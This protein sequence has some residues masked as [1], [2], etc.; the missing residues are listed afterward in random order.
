MRWNFVDL[1]RTPL[2]RAMIPSITTLIFK[3]QRP[4]IRPSKERGETARIPVSSVSLPG[5]CRRAVDLLYFADV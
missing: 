4:E 2:I 3:Y 1:E 5:R